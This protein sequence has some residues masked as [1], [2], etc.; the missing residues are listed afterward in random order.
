ML[1]TFTKE[2]HQYCYLIPLILS[3]ISIQY[4]RHFPLFLLYQNTFSLNLK[5]TSARDV[6]ECLSLIL[7][8]NS[9]MSNDIV[10][11]C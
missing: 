6:L 10:A 7:N 9:K 1:L 4:H 11:L 3:F 2:D 8:L 5:R